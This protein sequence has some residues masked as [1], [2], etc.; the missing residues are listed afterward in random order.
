MAL[1]YLLYADESVSK[2]EY[3][4][5]FY[6]GALARSGD[7]ALLIQE[8]ETKKKDLYL[9]DE[10]KWQRVTENYLAKYRE[11]MDLFFTFVAHDKIKVR[12][13]FTQ[14]RHIPM[15]LSPEQ[16]HN[17]YHLLYYQF[18][19]HAFGFQYA[20]PL[21][22]PIKLRFYLDKMPDTKEKNKKFREFLASLNQNDDFR[23]AN[24]SI[25]A[26]QISEVDSKEHVILQCLDIVLG[27]MQFRLNNLHKI[28]P[29]GARYRGKRT[30]A[31]EKLYKH[32]L[33]HIRHIYPGFNVGIS[34]GERGDRSNRWKDAY[35]HWLFI[36]KDFKLD[37]GSKKPK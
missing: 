13:M 25:Q 16:Y 1:E 15:G 4:S 30:L 37:P 9:L 31:K 29:E 14:N 27:A 32:I 2:G 10:I 33:R 35:R 11:I 34:T 23:A 6:G 19:K 28:K 24:L 7:L 20:N 12:I 21:D 26:D 17:Q 36:P 18:L 8:L 22:V 3:Y 5:N